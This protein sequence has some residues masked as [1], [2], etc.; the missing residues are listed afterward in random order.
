MAFYLQYR[1]LRKQVQQQLDELRDQEKGSRGSPSRTDGATTESTREELGRDIAS[2]DE[3]A[4][5]FPYGVL[6]GIT[7]A[8]DHQGQRY[9]QVGWESASD[10]QN[11]RNWP[12]SERIGALCMLVALAFIVTASSSIDAAIERQAAQAF[13]VSD[14]TEALGGTAMFLAGFGVGALLASPA[15]E[16][17]GRFPVYLA[18]LVV[19]GCFLVGAALAP[20]IG[21]QI[22]F[23]FLAGLSGA[24]PLTCAGGSINDMFN[25]REK[26]WAFPSFA[27]VGFGGPV[28]GPVIG[29][30]IG[31]TGVLS[32]RWSEWIMLIGVGLVIVLIFAA[33]K[34]TLGPQLLRY[35]ARHFR[36]LTGD[37]RFL[38]PA[39]AQGHSFATV[40]KTNFSRPF[41]LALEPIVL[42]FTLYLT[43]VYI[44][45]FTFLDGYRFIFEE[46]Y[47][48]NQGLSNLC[49]LG[50]FI[51]VASTPIVTVPWVYR[52]TKH[53]LARDGDDGTG[54]QLNQE[55]RVIFAM[56]GAPLISIG[57]F[58][59][60]WTD[61]VSFVVVGS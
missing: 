41:I 28:L 57:L 3:Y 27:L 49:F 19:F 21:A 54:S 44:V 61:Y 53:Q 16:L 55:T 9:Y 51:G 43:V 23:R 26:T 2:D 8:T 7:I 20:N 58:W 36:E 46:T 40:L 25:G 38:S 11:A 18:T 37:K 32:W 15:S 35:K 31:V 29:S 50:L 6:D 4:Q 17:V 47:G 42:L 45:L 14:V 30:Y 5:K 34:E 56:F 12:M 48:I 1:S 60:G 33:K 22:V 24:A 39:D 10:P 59:M 13:G 52:I